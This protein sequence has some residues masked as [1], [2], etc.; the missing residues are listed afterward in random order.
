MTAVGLVMGT[1]A[2]MSPEQLLG[3]QVDQRTD[4]FA[5]A[6]MLIETLT[7]RRPFEGGSYVELLRTVQRNTYRLPDAVPRARALD[8]LLRRCLAPDPA[9]RVSS[10]TAL[11]E[12]LIPLLRAGAERPA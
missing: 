5:C 8:D 6:V 2:Y 1:P 9:D 7:G 12:E 10:A 4:I 11:R 3:Q